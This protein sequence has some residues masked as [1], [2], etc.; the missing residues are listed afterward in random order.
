MA[1]LSGVK[2]KDFTS[3]QQ[4]LYA[5]AKKEIKKMDDEAE[6][7]FLNTLN[8]GNILEVPAIKKAIDKGGT[9]LKLAITAVLA[10]GG[11]AACVDNL[12]LMC[13]AA[14]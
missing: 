12:T 8:N 13:L 5:D 7:N 2:M 14:S 9:P 6:F 4:Q 11:A 10:A 3:D 1:G